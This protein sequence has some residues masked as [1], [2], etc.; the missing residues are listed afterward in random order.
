M[1]PLVIPIVA[2]LIPLVVA[3]VAMG[4]KYARYERELEHTERMR[5]LELGRPLPGDADWWSPAKLCA[6]IGVGVPVGVFFCAWM[7]TQSAGFRDGIWAGA[8]AVGMSGVIA[9]SVLTARH[10]SHRARAEAPLYP[11]PYVADADAYDVAG[12]RG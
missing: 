4:L 10:L 3:P 9:G 2:L 5:A 7:A 8:T 1:N 6:G 12:S 11:K